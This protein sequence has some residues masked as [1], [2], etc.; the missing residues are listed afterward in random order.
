MGLYHRVARALRPPRVR[1]RGCFLG[2]RL[3]AE[4]P[5][6]TRNVLVQRHILCLHMPE[7]YSGTAAR[8]TTAPVPA[9]IPAGTDVARCGEECDRKTCVSRAALTFGHVGGHC[10]CDSNV[11]QWTSVTAVFHLWRGPPM[12][13]RSPVRW[14]LGFSPST[15]LTMLL[16]SF[17]VTR[18][19]IEGG[20]G[21]ASPGRHRLRRRRSDHRLT[22]TPTRPTGSPPYMAFVPLE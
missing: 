21:A 18:G 7:G 15:P 10:P 12:W 13:T 20:T 14:S 2:R 16:S 22:A 11:R 9:A 3:R 6:R 1:Q 8:P 19:R 17:V 5:A 4:P